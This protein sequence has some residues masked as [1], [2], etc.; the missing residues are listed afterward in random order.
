MSF[1][2]AVGELDSIVKKIDSGD[3]TLEVMMAEHTRG[4]LLV[5]RCKDLLEDAEQ[6][7][8]KMDAKDLQ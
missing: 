2:E 4:Q 3:S 7:I 6:Q 8:Q 5:K 1:E